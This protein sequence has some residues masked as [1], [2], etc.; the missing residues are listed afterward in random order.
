MRQ[1]EASAE[2]LAAEQR[3]AQEGREAAARALR[4]LAAELVKREAERDAAVA[5]LDALAA[6]QHALLVSGSAEFPECVLVRNV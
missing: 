4:A 6:P 2:R 5:A 1:H 3:R